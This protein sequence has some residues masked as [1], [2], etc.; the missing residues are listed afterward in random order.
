L[1][2][3]TLVVIGLFGTLL[4]YLSR[5][6]SVHVA[7]SDPAVASDESPPLEPPAPL[8]PKYDFYNVLPERPLIVPPEEDTETVT[9]TPPPVAPQTTETDPRAAE[10]AS[11]TSVSPTVSTQT[12][13]K[14]SYFVQAG[15]FLSAEDADR[16]KASIAMLGVPA[17]IQPFK[18]EDG[19]LLHRVRIG[20]IDDPLVV[21]N[22]RQRLDASDI[23]SIAIRTQ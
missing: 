3:I 19:A 14:P 12:P 5:D 16:R 2:V 7:S 4:V 15:S 17:Q 6:T 23:P 20:P 1:L 21:E 8:K 22:L 13:S 9:D 11:A 10:R 18:R